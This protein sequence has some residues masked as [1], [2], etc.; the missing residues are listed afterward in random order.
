MSAYPKADFSFPV[1]KLG[2]EVD[3]YGALTVV[4]SEADI[5]AGLSVSIGD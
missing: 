3:S 5:E 1:R 4:T 2:L